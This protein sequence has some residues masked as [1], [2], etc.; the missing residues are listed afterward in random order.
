M[1]CPLTGDGWI[2]PAFKI[3]ADSGQHKQGPSVAHGVDSD[4]KK[5]VIDFF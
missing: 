5:Q 1:L 3:D 2:Y 4:V